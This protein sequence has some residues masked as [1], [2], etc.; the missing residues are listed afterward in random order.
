MEHKQHAVTGSF[1]GALTNV[2][3]VAVIPIPNSSLGYGYGL[4]PELTV[5]GNWYTTAAVFGVFQIDA[6]CSYRVWKN[7]KMG[8]TLSPS[9]NYLI[10]VFEKNSRVYPQFDAN[11][12]FDYFQKEKKGRMNSNHFYFGFSNWFDLQSTKAHG[13][14]QTNRM[15][16]SPQFGHTFERGNWNYT[17]EVK[18][19]APYASNQDIVVDYVSPF[20]NRGGMGTYFGIVYKF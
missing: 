2:P 18:L 20:G 11:Y 5:F 7:D 3:G 12:Y 9:V 19:L 15:V 14:K 17:I 13:L 6:G 16:F 8:L 4:K 10:D 1:G